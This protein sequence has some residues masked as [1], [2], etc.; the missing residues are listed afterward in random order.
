MLNEVG[1]GCPQFGRSSGKYLVIFK[2]FI[3]HIKALLDEQRTRGHAWIRARGSKN[4]EARHGDKQ[5]LGG[6]DRRIEFEGS[7][8]YICRP[9][10]YNQQRWRLKAQSFL[11]KDLSSPEPSRITAWAWSLGLSA[12]LLCCTVWP[13]GVTWPIC[14]FCKVRRSAG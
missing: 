7:L 14:Y 1:S 9:V 4:Y 11:V 10:S 5:Y 12:W 3:M 6:R 2:I 8:G 13:A